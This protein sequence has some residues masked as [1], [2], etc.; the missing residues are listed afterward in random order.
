MDAYQA[1]ASRREVRRYADRPIEP[2]AE[3]RILEAGRV[4]GSSKNRQPWRFVVVEDPATRE[5]VAEAVWASDNVRGAALVVAVVVAGKG[6]VSFD[7][8]RAA[9]NMLIAA[10]NDGIGSCPNGIADQDKMA[11]ALG[12][13]EDDHFAIVLTF[14]YPAR[15]VDPDARPAEDWIAR[16]DRRPLDDVVERR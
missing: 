1:L 9:Q 10:W 14:G 2:D 13:R 4:S 6:P 12:L 16:A 7:A 8:G 5:R 15:P 11:G 3:R